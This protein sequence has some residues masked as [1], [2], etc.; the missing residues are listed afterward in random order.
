MRFSL[1]LPIPGPASPDQV[2]EF[3][4]TADELG[5]HGVYMNS[6]VA[7]PVGIASKH[8]YMP[9]GRAPWPVSVN[10]PDTFVVFSSIAARTRRLRFG[11]M[12]V[13]VIVTHPLVLAKQAASLDAYSSGRFELGLGAGWMVEEAVAVGRATDRRW[14]RLEESIEILRMAWT[15]ETVSYSGQCYEFPAMG[16]YPHPV[17][18]D[19]LP[20]WIGGHGQRALEIAA[21][22]GAGVFLWGGY[23]AEKVAD[24]VR[25]V[26][27]LSSD[28]PVA[29][30]IDAGTP[31]AEWQALVASIEAAGAEMIVLSRLSDY[32]RHLQVIRE[33]A[34]RFLA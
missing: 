11:P 32:D 2:L 9:D 24:Y 12:V 19:R 4:E 5:Y 6:R 28:V 29:T 23:P 27:A 13:P 16:T 26:R 1:I 10:W 14:R 30:L 33:F 8:P 3:A 17:Q 18:G 20:I 34:A 15:L 7:R 21:R 25:R 22:F 31:A